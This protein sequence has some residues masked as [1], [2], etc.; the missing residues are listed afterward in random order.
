MVS[1]PP[2][3]SRDPFLT[4]L[5]LG[6]SPMILLSVVAFIACLG[7]VAFDR[8]SR[9]KEDGPRPPPLP[10]I[11]PSTPIAGLL[12]EPPETDLAPVYVGDDL[13][14][15]PEVMLEAAPELTKT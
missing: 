2:R 5:L 7:A 14:C 12:P 9:E 4:G 13:T 10:V 6:C 8:G 1:E 15:V 3:P 11:D